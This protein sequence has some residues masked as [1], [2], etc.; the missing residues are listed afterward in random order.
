M[1]AVVQT[2]GK[3]YKMSAGQKL[4]LEKLEGAVGEVVN[5]DQVLLVG[6]TQEN[7]KIGSPLVKGA[8]VSVEILSQELDDKVIVFKKKRRAN[9]RRKKGHRQQVTFVRVQEVKA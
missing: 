8:T 1:F 4:K 9:Y 6:S 7:T 3:Q 5:L 2:G